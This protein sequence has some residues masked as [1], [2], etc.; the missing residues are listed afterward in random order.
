MKAGTLLVVALTFV[1]SA[2]AAAE[3][4]SDPSP[5]AAM[6]RFRKVALSGDV[7]GMKKLVHKT[8]GLKDEGRKVRLKEIDDGFML[9]ADFL[10]A[11]RSSKPATCK[12]SWTRNKAQCDLVV[13]KHSGYRYTFY[14]SKGKAYLIQASILDVY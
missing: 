5:E 14:R 10:K 4:G 7:A 1:L 11:A 8:K 6:E 12:K 2:P 9:N 13:G 3:A